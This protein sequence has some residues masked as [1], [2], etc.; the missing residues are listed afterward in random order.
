[1]INTKYIHNESLLR[2][3]YL[4]G[5]KLQ[6]FVCETLEYEVEWKTSPFST[7]YI[8][9]KVAFSILRGPLLLAVLRRR[10]L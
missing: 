9:T 10:P 5:L 3:N 1:M 2:D 6:K 7:N 4:C 8:R